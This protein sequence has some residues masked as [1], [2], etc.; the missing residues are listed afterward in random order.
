MNNLGCVVLFSFLISLSISLT[1]QNNNQGSSNYSPN[2]HLEWFK[3]IPKIDE[4]TPEWAKT[5]YLESDNFEKIVRLYKAYY[6]EEDFQKNIHTQNYK[7][8]IRKTSSYT[9]D[10]GKI[11]VPEP[12]EE[13]N[14]TEKRKRERENLKSSSTNSWTNL[15]P[16]NTYDGGNPNPLARQANIYCLAVA[17]SNTSII[18]AGA[19]TGGVFKSTDKGLSWTPVSYDYAIG[20]MQDIK[21]DPLN[22]DIVYLGSGQ[23]IFKTTDGGATWNLQSTTSASIHQL[24]VNNSDTDLIYAATADGLYKSED[25]G[26]SWT[27]IYSG[28]VYDIETKPGNENIIYISIRNNTTVRPEI[29]KS[30]DSGTNWTLMDTGFY[31]PSNLSEASVSGCKI[32]V[33][34]A[35][36]NRIYAGIIADGKSGDNGWIGIYYSLDEGASWQEDSG[37]DGGPYASGNDMNTNW[38]VAGYSDGY[39]QGW[40]NFDIDVSHTDPDKLWIGT[41]WFCESGNRGGNIE[42]V[43]GTRNLSM[44]A[45][46][47]DIDVHG[48]DIWIASDGGINYSNDECQ[49]ME[50]RMAGI[51]AV[52]Y[53]GFGMGWNEDIWSGGRYHNGNAAYYENYGDGNVVALGGAEAATGYVNPFYNRKNYFSDSGAKDI[54]KSLDESV[55]GISNLSMFPNEHYIDFEY[56][57]VEWHPNKAN[58][59]YLGRDNELY[60]STD[61]GTN[62]ISLFTFPG[63]TRRFEI[64]RD[65]PNYIYMV[66]AVSYWDWRIYKSTDG[67]LNFVELPAPNISG[68]SWRKL[69]IALNPFDKDEIWLASHSSSNG[70]KIYSSSNGGTSWTNRYDTAIQNEEIEDLIYHASPSGDKIYTMTYSNFF[71]YDIDTDVWTQCSDGLPVFHTGFKMLPFFRDDKIRMASA[72]GVWELPFETESSVQA[73]PMVLNDSIFCNRDT[74]YFE[75]HSIINPNGASWSWSFDPIPIWIDDDSKRNPKVIFGSNGSI[76]VSLTVTNAAGISDTRNVENMINIDHQCDPQAYA[77]S[78]LQTFGDDDAAIIPNVNLENVTNFTM[79]GW[80]KPNGAQEGFAALVSSG[81]WCAHCD[82]TEGLIFNYWG[83]QLWY[84]WPGMA[85]NWASSSGIDIPLD[86]WSY[87]ALTIEPTKATL[88]LNDQKYVHNKN[89]LPG[90]ITDLYLAKG[91]YSNYFKGLIDEVTIWQKTLSEDEIYRLRHITKDAV[92][93][94]DPDL[95]AYYQNNEVINGTNLLDHAGSNHGRLQGEAILTQSTVPVGAGQ[96]QLLDVTAGTYSYNF[97]N[98]EST[99]TLNDCNDSEGK[100]VFTRIES[101][102]DV[103]PNSNESP[104]NYWVINYYS[105]DNSIGQ[106]ETLEFQVEDGSFLSNL[107]QASDAVLHTRTVNGEAMTWESKAKAVGL[108]NNLL[109]FDRKININQSTQIGL[110]NLDSNLI[111][112]DPGSPCG[113]DTIPGMTLRLSGNNGDYA[114]ITPMSLNTNNLTLSAWV[115]PNGIQNQWAGIVFCRGNGTTA[116]LSCASNNELRYHWD[117]NHY[118]WSSG[119]FLPQDV[120]SHVALVISP[121]QATIYLNG[122]AYT[123][124]ANHAIESFDHAVRVGSDETHSTRYFNGEIDEVCIWDRSLDIEEMRLLRH[125]TKDGIIPSDQNL[126]S[127]L[128]FNEE[129]EFIYDKSRNNHHATLHG[130]ASMVNS[131][132]PVGGGESEKIIIN[133]PGIY[134]SD[135]DVDLEFT[136]VGTQPN[137]EIVI[138]KINIGPDVWATANPSNKEY[139]IINNYGTNQSFTGLKSMSFKNIGEQINMADPDNLSLYRRSEN[140]YG[141]NW[142]WIANGNELIE[143]DERIIF[144]TSP[145]LQEFGQ[146]VVDRTFEISWIGIEDTDWNNPN[147]WAGGI[148]PGPLDHVTIPADVPYYP[149]VNIDNVRIFTLCVEFGASLTVPSS[150]NFDVIVGN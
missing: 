61:G 135:L 100:L 6:K 140:D 38:Y 67:G 27:S 15:G 3:D 21:V 86:E 64:S 113:V 142:S 70:N 116:G 71:H 45:D 96:A 146:F 18:Y 52:D 80:W 69:S 35:D 79:T 66:V 68:G 60:R 89:L 134:S 99:V 123:R 131:T 53:W 144:N 65:D 9:K 121:T 87:V 95:I 40:Y 57:E 122:V 105:E 10:N 77:G 147:N 104:D 93:T 62:F 7:Y 124:T 139:W 148:L 82:D 128:Q 37:F 130:S 112:L 129:A 4:S 59:L 101:D 91:H 14:A 32:G 83:N 103:N 47:Q 36:P 133:S 141:P 117:D 72:K 115:K 43:R 127:Y 120:W 49:T 92:I 22:P 125:L 94:Q 108:S 17:P 81:D 119:A 2:D 90:N 109:S 13:F 8:W 25:A 75:S 106:I 24:Y 39:H 55:V 102:P 137:G 1:A 29:I 98:L 26:S 41:I 12:G 63:A 85:D 34:P 150:F 31:S 30:T 44:H 110:S 48:D 111:E 74:V 19:E 58:T 11:Q 46:I 97:N 143:A 107:S 132:A 42:Y 16:T 149:I 73:M 50:T 33:T 20:N 114:S 84:K 56:S 54:P 88:Y 5:M 51:T 118:G 136:N 145:M 78:A 23:S 76:D 28:F 126:K 138:S